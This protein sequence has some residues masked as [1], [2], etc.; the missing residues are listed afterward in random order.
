VNH[1]V[2]RI[3]AS[4]APALTL[5]LSTRPA[6]SPWRPVPLILTHQG[7][8]AY[9]LCCHFRDPTQSLPPSSRDYRSPHASYDSASLGVRALIT[10]STKSVHSLRE[11]NHPP[12]TFRPR[13]S[14]RP[15]RL[16][17]LS[18]L[19]AYFIPQ[20]CTGFA[21]QGVV[22]RRG[23][24]LGFPSRLPSCCWVDKPQAPERTLPATPTPNF[25]ALLPATSAVV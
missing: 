4:L 25:R 19:Q 7:S 11:V 2:A 1:Q 10:T 8:S 23:A 5:D 9:E 12:A 16:T 17:P 20:P 3:L 22:P 13:R 18:A 15:R 24:V 6:V 21:L 14:S